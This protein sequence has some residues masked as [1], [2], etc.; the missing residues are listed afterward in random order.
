MLEMVLTG[1]IGPAAA[2]ERTAEIIA[3]ITGL[4]VVHD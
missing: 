3:A 2:A 1:R 4:P